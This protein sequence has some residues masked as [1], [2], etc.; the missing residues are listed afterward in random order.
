MRDINL[1]PTWVYYCETRTGDQLYVGVTCNLHH[2]LSE[3]KATQRWW[4]EVEYVQAYLYSDREQALTWEAS[5]IRHCRPKHNREIPPQPVIPANW[6]A[7]YDPIDSLDM[8][9]DEV[10]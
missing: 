9:A 6:D 10:A 1:L 2:R 5:H 4:P 7:N 3:H 8:Y